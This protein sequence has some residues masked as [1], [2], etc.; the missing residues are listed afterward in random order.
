MHDA[1]VEVFKGIPHAHT[2]YR[3]AIYYRIEERLPRISQ[4]TMVTCGSRDGSFVDLDFAASLIPGA[5]ARPHPEGDR[6]EHASDVGLRSFAA[7][8]TAW[9]DE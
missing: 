7:P 8:I 3:A 1:A 2:A 9:L 6:V 5:I 4:P